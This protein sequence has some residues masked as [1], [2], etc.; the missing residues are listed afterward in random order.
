MSFSTKWLVSE[1]NNEKEFESWEDTKNYVE[2]KHEDG[3]EANIR[4]I[5]SE[6]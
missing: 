5:A 3:Y 4:P 2:S 6:Q 1:S